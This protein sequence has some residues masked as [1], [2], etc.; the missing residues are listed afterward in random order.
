MPRPSIN[1]DPAVRAC[2]G[3]EC[4]P[5]PGSCARDAVHGAVST[6][7]D[8]A[9]SNFNYRARA[10]ALASPHGAPV[11]GPAVLLRLGLIVM[12]KRL[13]LPPRR[14]VLWHAVAAIPLTT[15]MVLGGYLSYHYHLLSKESRERVDHAYQ[16]LDTVNG[17][18]IAVEDAGMAQRDFVI[19][20]D[21]ADLAPVRSALAATKPAYARLHELLLQDPEQLLRV[22]QL[23]A[24]IAKR[25]AELAQTIDL[26]RKL[27]FE[28]A[29]A[30][31]A[32]GN[33]RKSMDKVREAAGAIAMAEHRQL[34]QRQ[35]AERAHERAIL[36]VG[37]SM[38]A[39][40]VVTR[41]LIA[42]L[43][44]RMRKRGR[45]SPFAA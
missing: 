27:G 29:R 13:R 37:V 4:L 10:R 44:A 36:L 5:D 33:G 20:G 32:E 35:Q 22:S 11:Q 8:F 19:T 41:L 17:L 14:V 26:R 34:K 16:V 39:L 18:F 31:L 15:L 1:R 38:A 28:N 9:C 24:A 2:F 45:P 42:W 25:L 3:I 23:E 12:L 40:S 30:A 6:H 21:E 43:L 7:E